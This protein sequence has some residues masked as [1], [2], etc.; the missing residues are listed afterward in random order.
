MRSPSSDGSKNRERE[1]HSASCWP[2]VGWDGM[3]HAVR[4]DPRLRTIRSHRRAR[5]W[6]GVAAAL[7]ARSNAADACSSW[8]A[9]RVWRTARARAVVSSLRLFNAA[10]GSTKPIVTGRGGW[11]SVFFTLID[12]VTNNF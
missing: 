9:W 3:D 7:C 10:F 6:I 1:S 5:R 11:K 4:S 8:R 12:F 2:A